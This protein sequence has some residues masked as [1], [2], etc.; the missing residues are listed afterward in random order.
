MDKELKR[1]IILDHYNDPINKGLIDDNSYIKTN[2]N[3]ETCIDNFDFMMKIEDGIV[4]DI[5][6]D[7][8]GCAVS[9]SANSIMINSLI[10][11]SID[12]VKEILLNY[13]NMIN[14]KEYKKDLLGELEVYDEICKQPNRKSCALVPS[15]SIKKL[16]GEMKNGKN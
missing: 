1:E 14:E 15:V 6:F 11:K 4:K 16:L 12:E 7:G 10:G 5:R 8:E 2:T 3:S 13:D 9:T